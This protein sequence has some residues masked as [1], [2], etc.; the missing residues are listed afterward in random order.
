MQQGSLRSVRSREPG[1][2][3]R[4][5]GAGPI[6]PIGACNAVTGL[7]H[8]APSFRARCVASLVCQSLTIPCAPSP[9]R[10]S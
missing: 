3:P 5:G 6:G 10:V 4:T 2:G 7:L 9:G 8:H 1:D